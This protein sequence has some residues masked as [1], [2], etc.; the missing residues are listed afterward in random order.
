MSA[1]I[2]MRA[3]NGKAVTLTVH[4]AKT[5]ALAVEG[6]FDGVPAPLLNVTLGTPDGGSW[7]CLSTETPI[8]AALGVDTGEDSESDALGWI[9]D[10]L[11]DIIVTNDTPEDVEIDAVAYQIVKDDG[12]GADNFQEEIPEGRRG[13]T[14][15]RY[16]DAAAFTGLLDFP[17]DEDGE[18]F[19]EGE[20]DV[21]D[22]G[23][24]DSDDD[25]N[26]GDGDDAEES[27]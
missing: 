8:A 6:E 23:L 3:E 21:M 15:Y 27:P 1:V 22:D 24:S 13:W 17:V 20:D 25:D 12:T 5:L 10:I 2:K 18:V 4:A 26:S 16:T 14:V 11:Y 9:E 7:P 19:L